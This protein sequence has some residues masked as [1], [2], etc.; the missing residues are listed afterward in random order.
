MKTFV[1]CI[2]CVLNKAN[3]LCDKYIDKA[4][5]RKKYNI[6]QRILKEVINT[7]FDRT[8]PF[9]HSKIVRIFKEEFEV[10]DFYIEEKKYFNDKILE[11]EPELEKIINSS[12]NRLFSA[13][14]LASAGNIIDFG[15]FDEVSFE[16]VK[17]IIDKTSKN[18]FDQELFNRLKKE[19]LNGKRLVY[20]GD[21]T[22]EIVFDKLFIKEI[23]K[24]YPD[25]EIIF[26]TRGEPI[27][28][29]ITEEDA[30]YVGMDKYAKIMNNKTDIAG[31]DLYEIPDDVKKIIVEADV[32]ISKG[33]GNF[34]SLGGCNMNIYY[35]FLCKC[36]MLA[37]KLDKE[38]YSNMFI[39]EKH[40]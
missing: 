15:A 3:Q 33:Q 13:L 36:D 20:L 16:M 6:M 28:N 27:L 12:K 25:L 31:T 8:T 26:M 17:N 40:D 5:K 34:E 2:P 21:N 19:L 22:G 37:N 10:D 35:I 4:D 9:I 32:I 18:Q 14:K 39:G 11:M 30:Y 23:A 1:D 38:K 29:D 24:E 7:E